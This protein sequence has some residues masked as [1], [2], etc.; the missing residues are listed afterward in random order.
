MNLDPFSAVKK[1]M[2]SFATA[3]IGDGSADEPI[4]LAEEREMS[5]AVG[6]VYTAGTETTVSVI[7]IWLLA[8]IRNPEVYERAQ[9]KIDR[10]VGH[11]RLGTPLP[12][13]CTEGS[14]QKTN[15]AG[16]TCLDVQWLSQIFGP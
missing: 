12:G 15:I 14:I 10:V 16:I 9:A 6:V 13:I 1:A 2:P 4:S 3:I 8:M 7:A 5:G 11:G